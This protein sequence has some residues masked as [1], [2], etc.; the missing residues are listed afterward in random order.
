MIKAKIRYDFHIEAGYRNLINIDFNGVTDKKLKKN[1][2]ATTL[3]IINKGKDE[4]FS[5]FKEIKKN[6]ILDD[7]LIDENNKNIKA[8]KHNFLYFLSPKLR[9]VLKESKNSIE[10]LSKNK[11][12]SE[13]ES[14]LL[15][16]K[17][18]DIIKS[19]LEKYLYSIGFTNP[20]EVS[21]DYLKCGEVVYK[22]NLEEEKISELVYKYIE[23]NSKTTT[24]DNKSIQIKDKVVTSINQQKTDVQQEKEI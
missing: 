3:D 13:D 21:Y 5:R 18:V 20:K 19:D 10:K 9:R 15:K 8:V 7:N 11:K 24:N 2:D 4:S 14:V 17:T 16:S 12:D 23:E 22:S 6:I 1:L